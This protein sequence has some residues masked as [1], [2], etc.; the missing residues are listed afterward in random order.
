MESEYRNG[1]TGQLTK[2]SGWMTGPKV[3]ASS[4]SQMEMFM[5]ESLPMTRQMEGEL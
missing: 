2:A 4:N 3:K 5:R 1:L